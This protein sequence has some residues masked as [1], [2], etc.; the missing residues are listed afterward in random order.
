MR[1][2]SNIER[3]FLEI[4]G[5]P[6]DLGYA[7]VPAERPAETGTADNDRAEIRLIYTAPAQADNEITEIV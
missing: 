6:Y 4:N 5:A 2:L 7:Q 3:D 1:P